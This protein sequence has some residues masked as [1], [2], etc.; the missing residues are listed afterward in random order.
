MVLSVSVTRDHIC[1]VDPLACVFVANRMHSLGK[2]PLTNL[3]FKSLLF[4]VS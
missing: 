2:E 1:S 3:V 4:S